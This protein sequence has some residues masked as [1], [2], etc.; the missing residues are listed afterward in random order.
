MFAVR[1]QDFSGRFGSAKSYEEKPMLLLWEYFC[2]R[3]DK[4]LE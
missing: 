4:Q 3:A 1:D 2:F